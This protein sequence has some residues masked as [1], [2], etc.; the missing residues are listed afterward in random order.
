MGGPEEG[1]S[2]QENAEESPQSISGSPAARSAF[3]LLFPGP[4]RLR[5]AHPPPPK[6]PVHAPLILLLHAR[7]RARNVDQDARDD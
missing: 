5:P 6:R 3:P 7:L 4:P 1:D 2:G